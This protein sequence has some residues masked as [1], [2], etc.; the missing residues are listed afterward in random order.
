LAP[1]PRSPIP[2]V[3]GRITVSSVLRAR[4]NSG[5]HVAHIQYQTGAY[6]MRPTINL[7]PWLLRRKWGGAVV[8]TFHDLRVPYLFPKA[9]PVREWANRLLARTA[10]AVI[11][12][13]PEDAE[14]LVSWGVKRVRLIPIG[15]NIPDNPP[16]G[17]NRAEWRTSH[18]IEPGTTLL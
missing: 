6:E 16:D 10:D 12:T 4:R 11:A 3:V 18:N 5:S 1:D 8:V 9:G 13:N 15:S 2:F 17:Y 7:L 14:Q